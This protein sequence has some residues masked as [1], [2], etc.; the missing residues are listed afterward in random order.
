MYKLLLY[1]FR[2]ILGQGKI[3]RYGKIQRRVA[4]KKVKGYFSLP[5][6]TSD[7]FVN[8]VS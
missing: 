2:I 1:D 3:K 4:F 8:N 5:G 7:E 6:T